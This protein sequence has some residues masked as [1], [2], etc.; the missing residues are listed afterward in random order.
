M[1]ASLLIGVVLAE[2]P[3]TLTLRDTRQRVRVDVFAILV[4]SGGVPDA[5]DVLE[6]P[7]MRGRF[8]ELEWPVREGRGPRTRGRYAY[9]LRVTCDERVRWRKE[10]SCRAGGG[11]GELR[12]TSGGEK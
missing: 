7:L 5:L 1:C 12:G 2:G 4:C 11:G 8:G 10:A 9:V 3:C 6:V